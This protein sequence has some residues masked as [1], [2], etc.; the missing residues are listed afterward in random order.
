M[1]L[2]KL[3]L[4]NFKNYTEVDIRFSSKINCFTGNNGVGKTNL[5]DAI[6][7]LSFCKSFFT[8][9]D[10]FNIKH[11]EQFFV[12]NGDYQVNESVE[13]IYCGFEVGK[14]KKF[15]RNKKEYDK[16]A[17]HIGLIPLV[18][19]SP[20][21]INLILGG[22]DERRKFID[23]IISQFDREYLY[24]LQNYNRTL[25]QRNHLLKQYGATGYFDEDVVDI[26]MSNYLKKDAI[27]LKKESIL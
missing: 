2:K 22:S 12:I 19:I 8:G 1:Y 14:R 27:F 17:D 24:A 7:Y 16:L 9:I 3:S 23:G 15:K 20:Y 13:N 18:M 10:S 11:N 26:L 21:D 6:Y 4:I 25:T 5:L